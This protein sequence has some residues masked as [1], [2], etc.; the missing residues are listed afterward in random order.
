VSVCGKESHLTCRIATIGAVC[1]GLDKLTD[2]EAIRGFCGRDGNVFAHELV[3]LRLKHGSCFETIAGLGIRWIADR[4]G[5]HRSSY[6]LLYFVELAFRQRRRVPA[7]QACPLFKKAMIRADGIAWS[8]QAWSPSVTRP[9]SL[10]F[11]SH[12]D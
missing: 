5:A 11:V 3:S 8:R 10:Q 4:K 6:S 7:A 2:S 1:V 9:I 12:F